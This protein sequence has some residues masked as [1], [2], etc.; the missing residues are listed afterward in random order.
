MAPGDES[1]LI[2]MLAFSLEHNGPVSIRYP[3]TGA[4]QIEREPQPIELGKAEVIETGRD[5]TIIACGTLLSTCIKAAAE[6]SEQG[7]DVGVINAR[8]VKP[9]D[10]AT[11]LR[12][13]Q[14]SLFVLTVE[15]GALQGGFGSAI[16]EAAA[17]AGIPAAH[18]RRLGVPDRFIEHGER[19]ELL[20]DLGLDVAGIV[21]AAREMAER[22][23][24][25]QPVDSRIR[26]G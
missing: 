10:T 24:L 6:L 21:R 16:L 12:A 5:G 25:P 23:D 17:D 15:E 2:A 20:A 19:S 26:A 18:V 14:Q 7:L 8:F 1:D 11:I 3:K 22:V 13:V 9:L 4:D